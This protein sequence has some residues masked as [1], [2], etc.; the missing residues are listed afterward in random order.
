[1]FVRLF[2]VTLS[3]IRRLKFSLIYTD[4]DETIGG[5][6]IVTSIDNRINL[7]KYDRVEYAMKHKQFWRK[8][9]DNFA[10]MG[11]KEINLLTPRKAFIQV[12]N[13]I[14]E[15]G[16]QNAQKLAG[17]RLPGVANKF[18]LK[19]KKFDTITEIDEMHWKV[20]EKFKVDLLFNSLVNKLDDLTEGK[21]PKWVLM[22]GGVHKVGRKYKILTGS[23]NNLENADMDRKY[24]KYFIPTKEWELERELDEYDRRLKNYEKLH[25]NLQK[26]DIAEH[27][28]KSL[29]R[30]MDDLKKSRK[31][32]SI[33]DATKLLKRA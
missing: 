20:L 27:I 9:T 21:V 28:L 2:P 4:V 7:V 1:M 23:E 6:P 5:K 18:Y 33:S 15:I 26:I 22:N 29:E 24:I 3:L 11:N 25:N 8:F 17:Q 14:R 19:Y 12:A 13:D 10:K 30:D 32:R 31:V 16:Y